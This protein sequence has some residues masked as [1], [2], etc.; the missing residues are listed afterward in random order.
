MLSTHKLQKG[1]PRESF[2][3]IRSAHEEKRASPH[4]PVRCRLMRETEW[5][6]RGLHE[7]GDKETCWEMAGSA[8]KGS[9]LKQPECWHLTSRGNKLPVS[10]VKI[11]EGSWT[12][13]VFL[14]SKNLDGRAKPTSSPNTHTVSRQT[15]R[16]GTRRTECRLVKVYPQQMSYPR[17]VQW[18]VS[19]QDLTK[20]SSLEAYQST[21]TACHC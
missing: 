3:K 7:Q 18:G 19:L 2:T 21:L 17:T 14:L 20:I 5:L 11:T 8:Q 4:S 13:A 10:S 9:R 1:A 15:E 6:S 12:W 16:T